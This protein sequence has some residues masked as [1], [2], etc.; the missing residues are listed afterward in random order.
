MSATEGT[1]RASWHEVGNG[2][3]D[4]EPP[5]VTAE[6][7]AAEAAAAVLLLPPPP[8]LFLPPGIDAHEANGAVSGP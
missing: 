7:A 5:E 1:W 6:A 3:G 2:D 4:V 8:L